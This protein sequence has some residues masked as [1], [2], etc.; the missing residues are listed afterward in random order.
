MTNFMMGMLLLVI[1]L[2]IGLV[3]YLVRQLMITTSRQCEIYRQE[4][5]KLKAELDNLI[6]RKR[7]SGP[8]IAGLEDMATQLT[9]LKL[10]RQIEDVIID[11]CINTAGQLRQG[12]YNYDPETP[13][14]KREQYK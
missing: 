2:L 9:N 12:P 6:E 1:F 8:T 4:T 7:Q 14:G 3:V 5:E 10:N 13:S 11:A